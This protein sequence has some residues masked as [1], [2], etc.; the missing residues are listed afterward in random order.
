MQKKNS[1]FLLF[2]KKYS[3]FINLLLLKNKNI[4]FI[5]IIHCGMLEVQV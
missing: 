3:S 2:N 5:I 1:I 4:F